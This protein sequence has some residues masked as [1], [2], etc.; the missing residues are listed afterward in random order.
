M[1]HGGEKPYIWKKYGNPSNSSSYF[2]VHEIINTD[3][4]PMYVIGMG[5]CYC[6]LLKFENMKKLTE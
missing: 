1:T 3:Y 5:K 4:K 2:A 6:L